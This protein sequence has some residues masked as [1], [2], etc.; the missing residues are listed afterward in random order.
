MANTISNIGSEV[1]D[2]ES[3]EG[4]ISRKSLQLGSTNTI[5]S[6]EDALH[7]PETSKKKQ[8]TSAHL[9]SPV[10][11]SE[12]VA[13]DRTQQEKSLELSKT[14]KCVKSKYI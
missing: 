1:T 5:V 13:K 3:L 7:L 10:A 12:A 9:D 11:V 2:D 4:M 8:S 6:S 14:K